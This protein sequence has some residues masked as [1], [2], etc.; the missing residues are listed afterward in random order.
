MHELKRIFLLVLV[1]TF[2]GGLGM[3]AWVG[4]LVASPEPLP[5][6]LD[7]RTNDFQRVFDDLTPSQIRRLRAVLAEH[8]AGVA[9]IRGQ[10]SEEQFRRKVEAERLSRERI[11]EILTEPQRAK[12]DKLRGRR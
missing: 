10:L 1:L 5:P 7:E 2:V 11:R 3:G 9:K 8:D 12:Y 6:S 4:T